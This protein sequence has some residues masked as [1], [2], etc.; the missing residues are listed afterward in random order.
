MTKTK[1]AKVGLH[2]GNPRL[3]FEGKWLAAAGFAPGG[4][5][6][7]QKRGGKLILLATNGGAK[8]R[9]IVGV[10]RTISQKKGNPVLDVCNELITHVLGQ[11][12]RVE[13]VVGTGRL[14]ITPLEA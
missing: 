13:V 11:C 14:T 9:G 8:A 1:T 12:G 2:R 6:V 3:W 4:T 10:E 7:C 5:F